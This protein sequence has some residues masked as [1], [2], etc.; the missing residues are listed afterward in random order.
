MFAGIAFISFNTEKEKSDVLEQHKIK[1][2]DR[3]K[4]YFKDGKTGKI[5]DSLFMEDRRN[6]L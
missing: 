3:F 6:F 4:A 1:N 5:N 2:F